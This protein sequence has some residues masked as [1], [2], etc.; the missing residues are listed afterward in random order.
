M[1]VSGSMVRL[2]SQLLFPSTG[3]RHLFAYGQFLSIT[4]LQEIGLQP[5]F[6]TIARYESRRWMVNSSGHPTIVPRRD[7]QVWG[8]IWKIR[9]IEL[10][11]LDILLGV[12][13]ICERYGS[14]ARSTKGILCVSEFYSRKD[15]R[16]G[17]AN[18]SLL[19]PI[20]TSARGWGFSQAYIDELSQWGCR[21]QEELAGCSR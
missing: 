9:E 18:S 21:P 16:P 6:V 5:D 3:Y 7:H 11:V 1:D 13:G 14:F 2:A 19:D 20:L 15:L 4:N 8:V 17:V 12:P 10:A